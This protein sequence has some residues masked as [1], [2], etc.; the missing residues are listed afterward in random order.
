MF[1]YVVKNGYG[2]YYS[3]TINK[4]KRV[5][6]VTVQDAHHYFSRHHAQ[7]MC[8]ILDGLMYKVNSL[9]LEKTLV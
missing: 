6:S 5:F 8:D 7:R 1:Y 4:H 9:T 2:L 3:Y